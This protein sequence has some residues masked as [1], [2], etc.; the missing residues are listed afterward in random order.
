MY[1]CYSQKKLSAY[2]DNQLND[3]Q[4]LEISNHIKE[5]KTCADALMRLE[6]LSRK[7]KAWQAPLVDSGFDAAVTKKIVSWELEKGDV[8]MKRKT[9]AILIPSGVLAG[10][11][12]FLFVGMYSSIP[13]IQGKLRES[14]D[15]VGEQFGE[16]VMS[17]SP[18]TYGM[19][20]LGS[21]R[22]GLKF[23]RAQYKSQRA[24]SGDKSY[25]TLASVRNDS[26]ILGASDRDRSYP[27]AKVPF[28]ENYPVDEGQGAVIVIQP[29]L[30]ATGQGEK[31][32]R[33]GVVSLEVEDGKQAYKKVSDLCQE[34]GGFLASSNFY[35][36]N[37]G[38]EAGTITLRIPKDKFT[39]ALDRLSALGKVR[40]I[41]TDSKDVS[42]EYANLSS[43]L[44]AAM[45][46]YKK[47]LE[48]LQKK[49][50]TI[51]EAVRLESELTPIL[52]RVQN[53]KDKVESLDNLISF[54]T[55]TVTFYEARVSLKALKD[56][57]RFVRE[58]ILAAGIKAV[59]LFA[60]AIPII[61]VLAIALAISIVIVVL[62]KN[63]VIR[64]FKRE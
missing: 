48:A 17:L 39:T 41:N 32:I 26:A 5:C 2:L 61:I 25:P 21:S 40:G 62:V 51:P 50:V 27:A 59:Q 54:T 12:V 52:R 13:G 58:S 38:R 18:A 11:L 20:T 63:L 6:A 16:Q 30:P 24:S 28:N 23:S 56:S 3:K 47:M 29:G 45:V 22:K 1:R 10:I 46:V 8:K 43:Q 37:E 33:T 9:I 42:Q 44:D 60:K 19:D 35:R 15:Q 36:D 55:I 4:K 34:L 64:F 14:T 7:L 57:G 53:L 31:V 49:Q